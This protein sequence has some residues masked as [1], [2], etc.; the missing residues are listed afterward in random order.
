MKLTV[1]KR[2]AKQ[3][4]NL[5]LIIPKNM[6]SFLQQGELVEVNFNKIVEHKTEE[7]K[8]QN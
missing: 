2:I 8:C 1:I 7:R 6:H 3:G 5:V 4:D